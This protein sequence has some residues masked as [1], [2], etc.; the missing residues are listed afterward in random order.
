TKSSGA[1]FIGVMRS[2]SVQEDLVREFDLRKVY[3]QK[4][5]VDARATLD[6]NSS[7][8][9]DRKS[10]IITITVTDRNPKRSTDLANAYVDKLNALVV[11]LS[12]S[13][14]HRERVFLEERL[15]AVKRDLDDATAQL[16]QFSSKNSMIDIQQQGKATFD[17][18][19]NLAGELIATQSQLEGLRQIYT[20]NNVRVRELS[21]RSEEL[22][23][24]LDKLSGTKEAA[25]HADPPGKRDDRIQLQKK[26]IAE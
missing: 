21:A 25:V 10:G 18:A 5:L 9:E 12:T 24:Q 1:L 13:S 14:A 15:T 6:Q 8:V 26:L 19:A 16:A 17:A 3:R 11:Q 2:Q 7:I 20:D 22:R 23:K 4:L